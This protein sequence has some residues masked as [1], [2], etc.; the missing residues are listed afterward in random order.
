MASDPR[1]FVTIKPA[2]SSLEL[3]SALSLMKDYVESLGIDLAYQNWDME[4]KE[5][6]GKYS[7][8]NAGEI[9]LALDADGT[10][11]G[12]VA[13]RNLPGQG[14]SCEMK[15]LYTLPK[16]RGYGAGKALICRAIEAA[17]LLGYT[18]MKL[19]T[20]PTMTK[21][22]ELYR[23]FSFDPTDCYYD[24]AIDGTLFFARGIPG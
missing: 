5:F 11:I 8:E 13:I 14:S 2:R 4:V 20:L 23:S 18:E 16:A 10:V 17:S 7:P 22:I 1:Q 3:K 6:P 9:L 24:A 15:R 21:A 19:D 12:C